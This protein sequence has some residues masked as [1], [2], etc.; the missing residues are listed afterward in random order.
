MRDQAALRARSPEATGVA[1]EV[2]QIVQHTVMMDTCMWHQ[3][4][5]PMER[6]LSFRVCGDCYTD[7]LKLREAAFGAPAPADVDAR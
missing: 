7:L 3:K 4:Q 5:V 6:T 2:V 1:G